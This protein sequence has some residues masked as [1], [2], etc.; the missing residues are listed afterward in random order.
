M[1]H[2]TGEAG[3][4]DQHVAAAE[5]FLDRGGSLVDLRGVLERQAHRLVAAAF[6]RGDDGIGAVDALV[7]ADDDPRPGLG[8][9]ARAGGAD[10]ARR[11]GHHRDLAIKTYA[12]HHRSPHLITL[13]A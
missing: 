13:S 2:H 1:R 9:E 7:I 5:L 12:S 3:G 11:A 10:A 4:I 8:E 6:E